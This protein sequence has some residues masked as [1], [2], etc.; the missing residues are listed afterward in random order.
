VFAAALAHN[1]TSSDTD[2]VMEVGLDESLNQFLVLPIFILLGAVLPWSEWRRLGWGGVLF[3]LI[4]LF[5]R[6]LPIVLAVRRPL[7]VDGAFASWLGWFGPIGVAALFYL[8]HV[9]EQGVTDPRV[10]AAGT[11][12]IA[13]S[14]FVHGLTAG[15]ARVAY[16]RRTG[17]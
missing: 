15:P 10:W 1:R 16:R 12:V 13:V 7:G 14:T 11:L 3:V 4:A 9:D 17:A 8:G 2:R 6:R 5:M